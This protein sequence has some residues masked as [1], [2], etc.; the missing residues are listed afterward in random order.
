M[1][2]PQDLNLKDNYRITQIIT[3]GLTGLAWLL[4]IFSS[5]NYQHVDWFLM[6]ITS[7][8]VLF[9]LA[10]LLIPLIIYTKSIYQ[11]W[12]VDYLTLCLAVQSTHGILESTQQAEF[13]SFTG[14]IFIL[15]SL[16]YRGSIRE[17]LLRYLPIHLISLILPLFFKDHSLTNSFANIID[18]FSL[19]VAGAFIGTLV[20]KISID[21]QTIINTSIKLSRQLVLQKSIELDQE[22]KYT[23]L[24][25]QVAHD[26]RSPLTALDMVMSHIEELPED[27]RLLMRSAC[28]RIHD[29]ANNLLKQ[30]Q[31]SISDCITKDQELKAIS[32]SLAIDEVVTEKR[33]ELSLKKGLIIN[34]NNNMSEYRIFTKVDQGKF[35]RVISNI[36]NNAI[37]ALEQSGT[38][39]IEV[40]P[41]KK[42]L[43]E[44]I[45]K[46][47]GK[48]IPIKVLN[49]I[50]TKGFTFGKESGNGVG[51]YSSRKFVESW[52]GTLKLQSQIK[53]GTTVAISLPV[54]NPPKYFASHIRLE[55]C[56]TLIVIDDDKSIHQV[57]KSRFKTI[58]HNIRILHFTCLEDAEKWTSKNSIDNTMFLVDYEYIGCTRNGLDF[59]ESLNI[60]SQSY[61][62]TS[63][64]EEKYVQERCE[65]L[66]MY[67]IAKSLSR[68]IPLNIS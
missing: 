22:K 13:Y 35:K 43:V 19:I 67:L 50:G 63:R 40:L 9:I 7:R 2:L 31:G 21:K 28:S 4:F 3:I 20:G 17:W 33:A 37:E 14:I 46:D 29:I 38:V 16:S 44:I 26:I 45:I 42:N 10:L 24:A 25:S 49:R 60:T 62:V 1:D 15:A 36:L 5:L 51:L 64:S 6:L 27:K 39:T 30:N 59:I 61:L 68:I 12:A 8:S 55:N 57:W 47:N 48:G 18:N 32:L 11:R 65:R 23:Q 34:K 58:D 66:N 52:G 53:T 56:S 41:S 54:S